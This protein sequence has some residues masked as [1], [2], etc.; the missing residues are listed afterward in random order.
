MILWSFASTIPSV[1]ELKKKIN[2][3]CFPHSMSLISVCQ[4]TSYFSQRQ[5]AIQ[6]KLFFCRAL[7][8]NKSSTLIQLTGF[9]YTTKEV[10][11]KQVWPP[12]SK[13]QHECLPASGSNSAVR[14]FAHC[15]PRKMQAYRP[16]L[17]DALLR[18]NFNGH[19]FL[20]PAH[21]VFL[22]LVPHRQHTIFFGPRG[23]LIES[24]TSATRPS[25][26]IFLLLLLLLLLFL[27][28]K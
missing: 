14:T 18:L 13:L 1:N 15:W 6:I 22:L 19:N 12:L 17:Q 9:F 4:L 25:A 27:L 16:L 24:S 2:M 8:L 21:F 28:H 10:F 7:A 26:T 20:S 5:E 11:V 3:I 23:P